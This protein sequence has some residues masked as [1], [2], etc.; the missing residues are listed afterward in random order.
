MIFLDIGSHNGQTLEEVVEH[1]FEQIHGF[2]PMP[3]QYAE[4]VEKFGHIPNVKLHNYGLADTGGKRAVYGSNR[5]CEASVYPTKVD[6]DASVVTYCDFIEASEVFALLGGRPF[7]VKMNC[8]GSE[9][10]ILNNLIDT[11]QIWKIAAMTFDLDIRRCVGFEHE[12]D[13]ILER[14]SEIGFDRYQI[15]SDAFIHGSHRQ[16]IA[17]W[18]ASCS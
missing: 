11:G 2:E 15:S 13:V 4:L 9:V 3:E 1:D 6:V 17:H 14:L 18:L 5:I 7:V 10:P 8:E 12:A 16:K